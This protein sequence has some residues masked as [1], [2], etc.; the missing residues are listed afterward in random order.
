MSNRSPNLVAIDHDDYLAEHVGRT[1]SGHQFFLTLPF[2]PAIGGAP[3]CEFVA[4]YL[5]NEQGQLIEAKID[6]FGARASLA[7]E[8]RNS[9]YVQRLRELGDVSFERIEVAPFSIER[10]GTTF[11]LVLREPE[12]DDD[13]DAWAVEAQPGNYMA[14]FE[15]WDS[16]NYDT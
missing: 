5:F 4:L 6:S 15:P 14:F 12:G 16:G 7:D 2:E 13:D 1:P 8:A 3:G 11:G 10:F 9:I